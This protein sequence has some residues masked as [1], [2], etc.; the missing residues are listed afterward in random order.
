MKKKSSKADL[1]GERL[2]CRSHQHGIDEK[3]QRK[4]V[5]VIDGNRSIEHTLEEPSTTHHGLRASLGKTLWRAEY[6]RGPFLPLDV[7]RRYRF[8]DVLNCTDD[9]DEI[10]RRHLKAQEFQSRL[11]RLLGM[12]E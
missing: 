12:N 2:I 1:N 10:K 3:L 7:L 5:L 9:I 4:Y 8:E 11:K 6:F